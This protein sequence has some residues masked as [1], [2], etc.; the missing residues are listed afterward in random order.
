MR[1]TKL[2][3]IVAIFAVAALVMTSMISLVAAAPVADAVR[4]TEIT[5][6]VPGGEFAEIWLDLEV[7]QPGTVTVL[8][9]WESGNLDGVGFHIL[10]EEGVSAV[11]GGGKAR[12]NNI[13]SGNPVQAFRGAS[14]QLEASFRAT[15]PVYKLIIYNESAAD[16]IFNVMSTNAYIVG[17]NDNVSDPN[18]EMVDG[19]DD[20]ASDAAGTAATVD[21]TTADGTDDGANQ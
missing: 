12:D 3:R 20:T 21:D 8:S 17:E 10:D 14:N 15:A 5:G 2:Q 1:K 18:A 13:A 4:S 19:D 7:M 6:T 9:T 11:A 16:A